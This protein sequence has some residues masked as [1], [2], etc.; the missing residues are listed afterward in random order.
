MATEPPEQPLRPAD[1]A[2]APML[3]DRFQRAFHLASEVHAT[4]VGKGTGIPYL[5]HLMSVA[6][7]ALE[8]GGNEDAAIAALLHDTVEDSAD[9][10]VMEDQ[11]RREFGDRVAA[12]VLGCS[13]A[14][15]VPGQPKAP[16]HQ[17]KAAY[18][19]HLHEE[20]D[21]DVLLVSACDKLH[22]ARSILT[23]LRTLGPALWSRISQHDP[24]AHLWYY[25][26]LADCYRS[27]VP[28]SLSDELNRV[29]TEMQA[30]ASEN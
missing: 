25:Q 6:A 22:N 10:T 27:K 3:T 21:P 17:R 30:L 20:Q 18:I 16:W 1:I 12:I 9:G 28:A 11:I 7:L 14:I 5:A 29:I 23:D 26:S 13:D 19:A 2:G 8:N 24:A 4:Q 15:A